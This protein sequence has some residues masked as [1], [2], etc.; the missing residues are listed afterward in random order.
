MSAITKTREET[1]GKDVESLD[2]VE[3]LVRAF[4]YLGQEHELQRDMERYSWG[5]QH[6]LA[7]E[8]IEFSWV[9]V[10]SFWVS[11]PTDRTNT[12]YQHAVVVHYRNL[13]NAVVKGLQACGLSS[14]LS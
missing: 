6:P 11:N 8:L 5:D 13:Y 10:R 1:I 4:W 12:L 9:S 2:D 14:D 7:I 3:A